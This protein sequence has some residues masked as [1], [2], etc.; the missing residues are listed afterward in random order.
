MKKPKL[1]KMPKRPK[2]SASAE[3]WLRYEQRVKS[4]QDRNAKKLAPYLKAQSI[5]ERVKKNV[6][7]ISGKVA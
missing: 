1:I 3:V 2:E 5:K 6:S 7:K 4:V